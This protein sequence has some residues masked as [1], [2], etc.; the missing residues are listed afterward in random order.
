M[1]YDNQSFRDESVELSGNRFHGC[2]F[3]RCK[4]V[5]RGD[6]SPTFHDNHFIESVFVLAD[7]VNADYMFFVQ[8]LSRGAGGPRSCRR[9][10]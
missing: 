10:L 3:E 9:Y 6:I 1:N 2:T 5:Y 7:A 4:L 8:H